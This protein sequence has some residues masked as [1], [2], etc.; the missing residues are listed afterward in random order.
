MEHLEF[1]RSAR[2]R[3]RP[4]GRDL[5][6]IYTTVIRG[7]LKKAGLDP[8]KDVEWVYGGGQSQRMH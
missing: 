1:T 6:R 2:V 7:L 3:D 4:E 5:A 8:D